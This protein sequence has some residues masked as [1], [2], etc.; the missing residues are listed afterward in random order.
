MLIHAMLSWPE[1]IKENLWPFAIQYAIDLHNNTPCSCNVSPLE[2]FS[3]L[4]HH[5]ILH[6]FHTFGC[7]I[8]VLEPTLCQNHKIPRWK[9]RSRVGIF[10]GF[11]PHHA[12]SVPLIL[13]TTT[14][15]VSSQFHV[16][17]DDLFF[18]AKYLHTNS[19]PN[20]WPQLFESS[21][22]S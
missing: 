7:P 16:V 13:S 12:S 10:L 21:A 22:I 5:N 20:N 18:T 11:S 2:I 8:Y 6:K 14:G 3:G 4:K 1:I 9:P 17:F 15:L 19:I